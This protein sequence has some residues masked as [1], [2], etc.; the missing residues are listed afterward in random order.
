MRL[1]KFLCTFLT[2]VLIVASLS[3]AVSADEEGQTYTMPDGFTFTLP[4]E[5]ENAIW[6]G[7]SEDDPILAEHEMPYSAITDTY[8][9]FGIEFQ[10]PH[11]SLNQEEYQ[12]FIIMEI[13]GAA[14]SDTSA[15]SFV[16]DPWRLFDPDDNINT[17]SITGH[18]LAACDD[19]SVYKLHFSLS[20]NSEITGYQYSMITDSGRMHQILVMLIN[21]TL[22]SGEVKPFSDEDVEFLDYTA[23]FIEGTI[24]FEGQSVPIEAE[25]FSETEAVISSEGSS[26]TPSSSGTPDKKSTNFFKNFTEFQ[27]PLWLFAAI[28]VAVLVAGAKLSKRREWQEQPLGLDKSKAIQGFAAVA[29]IL[30]HLSQDLVERSGP[31]EF[32]TECGVIF[33]GIFFFFSG[34]GLYTSLKTKPDYL[35]GFLR[36]RFVTILIPFYSCIAVFTVASCICGAKY[37][38]LELLGIL[39]G[40]SLINSHMWYIVEIAILYL[41]FFIFYRLIKNRTVATILMSIFVLGM[42]AGSLYLCHGKDFSCSYWFMGEWWYN[43]TF[44]FVIGIIVSKHSE[45]FT[46]IARKAY[47]ILLPLFGVLT[48]FFYKRT[49]HA[50]KTYSY[51]SEIPGIDPAYGDKL[52]CL[53][54]QLPFIICFVFFVLLVMLKV[55]FGNPVLKFL[56]SISLEL[57]LIHN[58]FLMGLKDGTIFRVTSPSMY[59]ILTIVMAIGAATIISGVD[60]YIIALITGKLKGQQDNGKSRNHA[61]DVMRIVMAFLVVT[62]HWP[63]DGKAGNVFITFGKTAVPFF[64]VVC[65]YMLYRDDSKEMMKRLKKQTIRMLIFFVGANVFYGVASVIADKISMG[66]IDMKQYFTSKQ[67]LDFVLYNFSPFSEHLWFLGSLLYALVI[68]LIL[69]KLKILK[70]AVFAGPVLIA[71][72]VILSHLNIGEPYQLRNA[73][74]VGL[75]YPLTGMLI[76]RFEKNIL[77]IK[78]ISVILGILA[79]IASVAAIFELN[80]YKQGVN[81]P[82]IGCE[83]LTIVLVLL[84]LKF[85]NFGMGTYAEK[86]GKRSSL[87]IY[88]MH[89]FTMMVFLVSGNVSFFGRYGAVAIFVVTA[90][91]IELY[92]NIKEAVIKTK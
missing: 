42:M 37:E 32:L 25:P 38:P 67:I 40:W 50:L 90:V 82:F 69:N 78:F 51:W 74:L 61:I 4:P 21:D 22:G 64:L 65:G 29:I 86:I 20:G 81:V 18:G 77:N 63:F 23:E 83:I 75:S 53:V 6:I 10:A 85:P 31:F 24:K 9:H 52:R 70:H 47:I 46:K 68:M 48:F 39:S 26:K 60:K 89:I 54:V 87:G 28:L 88:I 43:S 2:V 13:E 79:I 33:V 92:E 17:C 58:L 59:I 44:L 16:E 5:Y 27:F 34:Y 14:P 84:C 55:K 15:D 57:Y 62:I 91:Y 11:E 56:G 35:K 7:M 73:I 71:A 49:I 41:A 45:L 1:R 12:F 3:F 72:Y 30:H 80:T 19:L 76:R 8:E 66:R 36:K